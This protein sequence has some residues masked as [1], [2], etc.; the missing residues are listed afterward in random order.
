MAN[1]ALTNQ[2][3]ELTEEKSFLV[4]KLSKYEVRIVSFRIK[5]TFTVLT[6]TPIGIKDSEEMLRKLIDTIGA[7]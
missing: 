7:S 1:L 3:K 5:M 4:K 2:V 6:S